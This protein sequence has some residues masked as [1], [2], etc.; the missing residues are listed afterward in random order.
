MLIGV[1]PCRQMEPTIKMMQEKF[2][3][4][5]KKVNVDNNAELSI[6]FGITSIPQ[7]VVVEVGED[8]EEKEITRIKGGQSKATLLEFFNK[9]GNGK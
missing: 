8:R 9:Y 5:I 4:L 6:K 2:P 1:G 7:L 3:N